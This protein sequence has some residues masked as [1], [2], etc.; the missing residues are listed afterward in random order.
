MCTQVSGAE[1]NESTSRKDPA[2]HCIWYGECNIN[3]FGLKQNCPY[4]GTAK[5]IPDNDGIEIL[6]RLCPNLSPQSV[7]CDSNQ[8]KTMDRSISLAANFLKRCPSCMSNFLK[9]ICEMTCSP[10]QSKFIKVVDVDTNPT[11]NKTF[12]NGIEYYITNKYLQGTYDSC[13]QVSVPSTGQLAM[14]IMCGSWGAAKCTAMR[15]FNYM[16]TAVATNPFVPFN[17]HFMN[18]SEPIVNGFIPANPTVTPCNKAVNVSIKLMEK[19]KFLQG[20]GLS[21]TLIDFAYKF[22][23]KTIYFSL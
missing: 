2:G 23:M 8:L 5:P 9:Q 12:I 1:N 13:K 14:D 18:T 17:I 22:F 16:G 7:C 19:K 10:N 15:W 3:S 20:Q 6:T 21:Q 11:T 4:N